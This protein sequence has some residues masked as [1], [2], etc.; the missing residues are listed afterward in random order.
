MPDINSSP[1]SSGV[2]GSVN[3]SVTEAGVQ[4]EGNITAISPVGD[5]TSRDAVVIPGGSSV[6]VNLSGDAADAG[7]TTEVTIDSP[8][9]MGINHNPARLLNGGESPA[10]QA[11]IEDLLIPQVP[12]MDPAGFFNGDDQLQGSAAA[13]FLQGFDGNDQ[14]WGAGGNDTLVGNPGNDTIQGDAGI[15]RLWGGQGDDFLVGG[16]E[17]DWLAGNLGNDV[18]IGGE[19]AD[20]FWLGAGTD[21]IVD[22]S[23]RAGDQIA[24][25]HRFL[26]ENLILED[27]DSN[28]DGHNDA[29]SIQ[30]TTDR[31]VET[32]GIV[33]NM[34]D[35]FGQVFLSTNDFITSMTIL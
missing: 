14:L 15:D 24:L 16:S 29:T 5:S 4:A 20:I 8:V 9:D 3:A 12:E 32:L 27:F 19:G 26:L 2:S 13:D 11:G 7:V 10:Q 17:D 23:R 18:L 1:N 30:V 35:R 28:H 31:G 22:F 34:M 33:L 6:R 21:L 25:A